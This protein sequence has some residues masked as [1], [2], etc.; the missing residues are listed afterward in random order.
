MADALFQ[1]AAVLHAVIEEDKPRVHELLSQ[2]SGAELVTF[3]HQ[4]GL[5]IDLVTI[6][7][8]QR[9]PHPAGRDLEGRG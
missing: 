3:Y 7:H 8:Q 9:G 2:F 4:L 6:E 5:L 1:E